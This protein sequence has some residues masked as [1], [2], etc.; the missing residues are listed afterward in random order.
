VALSGVR[1]LYHA[2]A[3]KRGAPAALVA[4][5]V[6]PTEHLLRAAAR[7]GAERAVLVSSF[8]VLGVAGLGRGALVDEAAPLEPRPEARDAYTFAKHR[9]ELAGRRVADE[10][11]LALAVVRPGTVFGPGQDFLGA[12]LGLRLPGLFLH[13][14]GDC[15]VPLTFVENC[16]EAVALAGV[17]PAAPGQALCLVDDDLPQARALLARY[18]AEVEGLR[19]VTIPLPLLRLLARAN[20]WYS[21]RTHGHL[22]PV[23]TPYKVD[24]QWRPQRFSNRRAR[25]VLGW[26]PRVPMAEALDRTFAAL[27]RAVGR[28]PA[29]AREVEA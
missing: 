5:A 22:P 15:P 8:A 7:A 13:L 21:A 24:S 26:A 2:A 12:R 28:R 1:V 6:P 27:A 9:Q 17:A 16:A 20:A 11:G 29:G 4:A 25:E 18:R 23:L 10:V 3:A 14:G 19:S